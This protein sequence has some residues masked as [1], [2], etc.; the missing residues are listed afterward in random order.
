MTQTRT[1][2]THADIPPLQGRT[3]LITGT[4]GLGFETALALAQAGA[5]VVIAGRSPIKGAAAVA[6]IERRVPQA[7]VSFELMNLASL[8]SVERCADRLKQ[9]LDAVDL[10]I[11]N[12]AVMTPP[13]RC[14][15]ADGFELQFGTNHLGHFALT[16]H[17]LPLLTNS[18]Q[19]RVVSLSSV[20][21]REAS[22]HFDDLQFQRSYQPMAAYGQSKLACLMFALEMQ[23][24]SQELG[25]GIRSVAAHPGISR[26]ELLINGAGRWSLAGMVRR[27]AW[28][29]FQP[30]A[31]GALPT[32]YAATAPEA[33]G[34]GYYGPDRLSETRGHPAPA[35]TPEAALDAAARRRLW[36]E[37]E[38]ITGACFPSAKVQPTG[39]AR[40]WLATA[41]ADS[42]T[43]PASLQ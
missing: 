20:A 22:I 12:A 1:P 30:A 23:R 24:L 27:F 10:L 6:E 35:R 38:W 17:L 28:F 7:S 13:D 14:T 9:S 43:I 4:G 8:G 39:T 37:S 5:N 19:A 42:Q 21:A 2:W 18:G 41:V 26:T 29:L 25:W 36:A 32:L 16:A 31:Q 40:S 11:N 34:G 15:T 33:R 3:A